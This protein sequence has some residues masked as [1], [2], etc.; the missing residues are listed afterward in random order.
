MSKRKPKKGRY[1]FLIEEEVYKKFSE[2]CDEK[3]L[4]RSK[5]IEIM[6]KKIMEREK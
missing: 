2:M 1:N 6:L 4:V 3:G 5:Q